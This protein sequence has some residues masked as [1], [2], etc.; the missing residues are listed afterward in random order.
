MCY[1][2]QNQQQVDN[3]FMN[4]YTEL[5]EAGIQ[6]RGPRASLG[7]QRAMHWRGKTI[8]LHPYLFVTKN[9]HHLINCI[10]VCGGVFVWVNGTHT[11]TACILS[12]HLCM[13]MV[14]KATKDYTEVTCRHV[15]LY[16][17]LAS[18]FCVLQSTAKTFTLWLINEACDQAAC[19]ACHTEATNS[20]NTRLTEQTGALESHARSHAM[21][22]K[23][24][25]GSWHAGVRPFNPHC[26]T[27]HHQ[28][29]RERECALARGLG[30]TSTSVLVCKQAV[31]SILSEGVGSAT[32]STWLHFRQTLRSHGAC[33]VGKIT[34][35]CPPLSLS[36]THLSF[37]TVSVQVSTCQSVRAQSR[38]CKRRL[39]S[40][41]SQ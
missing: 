10:T 8:T 21:A 18:M 37:Y 32:H 27:Q 15:T 6:K 26:S 5:I 39:Y 22:L 13:Y 41:Q 36:H 2:K 40:E 25:S 31:Y 12:Y 11:Q 28:L 35:E 16:W 23:T 24:G 17:T 34:K 33:T 29:N 9:K 7:N 4:H 1:S 38:W 3:R 20:S 19:S 14:N 30:V